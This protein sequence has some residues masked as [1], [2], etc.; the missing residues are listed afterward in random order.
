MGG[1]EKGE[2][3]GGKERSIG[4]EGREGGRRRGGRRDAD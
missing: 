1:G 3:R 2:D 4:G